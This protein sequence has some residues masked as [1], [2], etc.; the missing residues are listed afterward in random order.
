M[1]NHVR[2]VGWQ[3]GTCMEVRLRVGCGV[4]VMCVLNLSFHVGEGVGGI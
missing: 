4:C 2:W 3:L 1:W